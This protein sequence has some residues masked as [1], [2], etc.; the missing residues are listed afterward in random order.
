[1]YEYVWYE[2]YINV[3]A[4]FSCMKITQQLCQRYKMVHQRVDMKGLISINVIDYVT[5]PTP[6]EGMELEDF[7]RPAERRQPTL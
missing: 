7:D 4:F 1:M 2:M 3:F 5:R 6:T